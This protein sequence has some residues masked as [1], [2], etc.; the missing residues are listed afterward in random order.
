MPYKDPEQKRKNSRKYYEE[1]K[2]EFLEYQM[3]YHKRNREQ[4][5]ENMAE[6]QKQNKE[7]LSKQK[8]VYYLET[9]KKKQ[10]ECRAQ[11]EFKARRRIKSKQARKENPVANLVNNLRSRIP[12]ALKSKKARKAGKTI[13]LL[14][15]SVQELKV[16]L[17][18][19][20]LPGMTWG[21]YGFY[22]WHVDHI[23]PCASFDLSKPEQQKICF[24]FS[25]LQP[26]WAVDNIR[27][28]AR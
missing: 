8:K 14:G 27:K 18:E 23:K 13:E 9:G 12:H 5:L 25:N 28:G 22:G 16:R 1:N 24:H 21:N 20:F 6:Y 26:L 2:R 15:C 3:G 11:P 19:I 4:I 7:K 10:Q 17:E